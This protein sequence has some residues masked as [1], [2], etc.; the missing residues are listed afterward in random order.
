MTDIQTATPNK[1]TYL[2]FFTRDEHAK[3]TK[4]YYYYKY[5]LQLH[6]YSKTTQGS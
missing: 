4:M 5:F 1:T 2:F 6:T 3:Q